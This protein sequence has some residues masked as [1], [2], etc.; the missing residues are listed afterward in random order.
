MVQIGRRI[1]QNLEMAKE[2]YDLGHF[3][4]NK[5]AVRGRDAACYACSKPVHEY[6]HM[7]I[8]GGHFYFH[9]KC[10]K[11]MQIYKKDKKKNGFR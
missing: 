7:V 6:V 4:R 11:E 9:E 3:T 8:E 10:L 1:F 5:G 2:E